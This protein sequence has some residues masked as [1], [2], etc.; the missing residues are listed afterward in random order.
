MVGDPKILS[1]SAKSGNRLSIHIN[2]QNLKSNRK[3]NW[4]IGEK[5]GRKKFHLHS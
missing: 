1:K 3:E 4:V 5:G 2:Q